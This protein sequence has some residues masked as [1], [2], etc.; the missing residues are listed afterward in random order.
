MKRIY[1]V[2][3]I[4]IAVVFISCKGKNEA[5][6][7]QKVKIAV[8]IVPY[9]GIVKEIGGDKVDVTVLV[10]PGSACETYE[11]TPVDIA[12]AAQSEI[13]FSVGANYAFEKNLVK[14]ISENYSNVKI[15]DCSAG[16]EV[17]ENNPHLW[18][19]PYG[20]KKIAESIC[21][22]LVNAKPDYAEYFI[23]NKER[24]F[25]QID[26]ADTEIKNNLAQIKLRKILVFH[27]SW[28]YFA[29]YYN[30]EQIAIENEGKEPTAQDLKNVVDT[31]KRYKITTVYLEPNTEPASARAIEEELKG[32]SVLLNPM[33]EDILKNLISVSK[34]ISGQNK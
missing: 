21:N 3:L 14:S 32:L 17:K 16:L 5:N 18:L 23:G 20:L 6:D 31:A 34:K 12:K 2:L 28:L 30:L 19:Y 29:G 26:S 10:P 15:V 13:Y 27:P 9:S 25:E 22:T 24:Y 7:Q 1:T 4:I 8:T 11:P 33:E